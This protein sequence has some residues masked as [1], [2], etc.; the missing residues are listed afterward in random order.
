MHDLGQDRRQRAP[1]WGPVPPHRR[2]GSPAV[3]SPAAAIHPSPPRLH[4]QPRGPAGARGMNRGSPRAP[5]PAARPPGHAPHHTVAE[6]RCRVSPG[7]CHKGWSTSILCEGTR[8]QLSQR[9]TIPAAAPTALPTPSQPA[10]LCARPPA[11]TSAT[12]PAT[13]PGGPRAPAVAPAV[14]PA[15][16]QLLCP[17]ASHGPGPAAP[18][19]HGVSRSPAPHMGAQPSQD[20]AAPSS[21]SL[22]PTDA[23]RQGCKVTAPRSAVLLSAGCLGSIWLR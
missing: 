13:A 7:A 4:R 20:S 9:D 6:P 2:A 17:N 14:A 1:V 18:G 12:Q 22:P 16:S 21:C 19:C 15:T 5:L 23:L 3:H 8:S 11:S 10:S